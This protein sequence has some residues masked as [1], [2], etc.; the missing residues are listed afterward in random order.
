MTAKAIAGYYVCK[1]YAPWTGDQWIIIIAWG[2]SDE[3][4]AKKAHD[5]V[6]A[7]SGR[8]DV[9]GPFTTKQAADATITQR[10]CT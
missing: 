10:I 1:V 8:V 2:N 6:A 3:D 5:Q 9:D 4:A 7:T